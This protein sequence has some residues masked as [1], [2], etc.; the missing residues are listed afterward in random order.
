MLL[1]LLRHFPCGRRTVYVRYLSSGDPMNYWAATGRKVSEAP[2]PEDTELLPVPILSTKAALE[3]LRQAAPAQSKSWLAFYSSVTG[4]IV[5]EPALMVLPVDDH[6][7]HRGHAVFDTANV[8]GGKVYGLSF[9]LDRLLKSAKLARIEHA[10]SKEALRNIVLHTVAASGARDGAFVRYWLS[11]GRGDFLVSPSRCVPKANFYVVVHEGGSRDKALSQE[12]GVKEALVPANIVHHKPKMLANAKT[13]NYLL[14]A[15]TA[16]AAE[17]L[18]GVLG[19]GIDDRGKVTEQATACVAFLGRDKILRCPPFGPILDGTT[20]RRVIEL[21]KRI[22]PIPDVFDGIIHIKDDVTLEELKSSVE[23]I[24]FGGGT[25]LPIVSINTTALDGNSFRKKKWRQYLKELP[26]P[27]LI[28]GQGV[29]G[30]LF[31]RIKELTAEDFENSADFLDL[32]PYAVYEK[33]S[34]V[35]EK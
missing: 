5:T 4:G 23:V 9:H 30:P 17:D 21:L 7:V 28:I 1:Q 19:I 31:R 14:N 33:N 34:P 3:A 10:P 25:V 20:L 11:V 13:T 26:K 16:M 29:P 35:V 8:T 27:E 22:D 18:G 32:P 2:V 6:M 24:S 12:K 15:L